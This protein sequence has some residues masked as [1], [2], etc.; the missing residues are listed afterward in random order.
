MNPLIRSIRSHFSAVLSSLK[1][2][3][4][5]KSFIL[6]SF[7]LIFFTH[8]N[9]NNSPE[10]RNKVST[11]HCPC[12]FIFHFAVSRARAP[13]ALAVD[14]LVALTLDACR[15]AWCCFTSLTWVV[16]KRPDTLDP[17]NSDYSGTLPPVH[18]NIYFIRY[19]MCVCRLWHPLHSRALLFHTHHYSTIF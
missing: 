1:L 5:I 14:W 2:T 18:L 16:T 10:K 15:C 9:N 19:V 3:S 8:N 12:C 4:C 17:L 7:F 11:M 13:S 6:I